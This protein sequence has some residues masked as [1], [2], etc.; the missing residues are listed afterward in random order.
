MPHFFQLMRM[1]ALG[2]DQFSPVNFLKIN[3]YV[4]DTLVRPHFCFLPGLLGLFLCVWG[5]GFGVK[6]LAVLFSGKRK[7]GTK[8]TVLM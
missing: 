8:P 6:V 5:S 1:L 7:L 2:L 4:G 3:L